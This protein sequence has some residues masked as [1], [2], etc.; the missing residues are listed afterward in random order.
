M[1]ITKKAFRVTRKPF[2][3]RQT[4][5]KIHQSH[6]TYEK[7]QITEAIFLQTRLATSEEIRDWCVRGKFTE[8]VWDLGIHPDELFPKVETKIK[9]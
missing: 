1:K 9:K 5:L 3:P 8:E 7:N 2:S 6:K 4:I